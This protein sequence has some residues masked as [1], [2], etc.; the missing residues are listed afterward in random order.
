[1]AYAKWV[2]SPDRVSGRNPRRSPAWD[3]SVQGK[4]PVRMS[5]AGTLAQ[6][7]LVMSPR[8]G[9]FGAR[10]WRMSEAPG[11]LSQTHA[12]WPPRTDR[13]PRSRPRYPLKRLPMRG[14]VV[15]CTVALLAPCWLS[16]GVAP[17]SRFRLPHRLRSS[18]ATCAVG[19]G[20][21]RSPSV[22]PP[23]VP[24]SSKAG[25]VRLVPTVPACGPYC[26]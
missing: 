6:S 17:E 25:P 7:T 21:V 23:V 3:R 5:T 10:C 4:P 1:M 2:H 9:A 8:L 20:G 15:S 14:P 13:T 24:A 26:N 19:P 22:E 18:G 12:V 11:S 16:W